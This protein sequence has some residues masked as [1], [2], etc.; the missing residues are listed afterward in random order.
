MNISDKLGFVIKEARLNKGMS[1]EKLAE[2]LAVTPTHV[3][4][5]ESGRRKPSVNILFQLSE[6]LDFSLDSLLRDD[7]SETNLKA[8]HIS[9]I[10]KDCSDKELD[11]ISDVIKA[12]IK[13]T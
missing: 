3:K 6:I 9:S 12:I 4:H 10:L 13:N 5:L 11:T 7:M 1:Q 8:E 2:L